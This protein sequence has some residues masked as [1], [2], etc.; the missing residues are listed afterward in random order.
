MGHIEEL[1]L[2]QFHYCHHHTTKNVGAVTKWNIFRYSS[3]KQNFFHTFSL[4]SR[5]KW[6]HEL[7][8]EVLYNTFVKYV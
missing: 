8:L 5:K 3:F 4:H 1:S 6:F 2:Q 7:L